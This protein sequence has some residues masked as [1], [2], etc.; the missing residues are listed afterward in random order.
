VTILLFAL[1]ASAPIPAELGPA[2]AEFS[3]VPSTRMMKTQID[4][5]TLGYDRGRKQLDFWLR[6]RVTS[7]TKQQE[8]VTWADTRTCPAARRLLASMRDIPVPKFAPV[9]SSKGP[10][11]ILDGV[12]YSLRTYSDQ[13]MLTDGT[14]VGTPLAV[15]IDSALKTLRPC[16]TARI[17]ER[18]R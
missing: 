7:G 2:W 11:V 16:W 15:W 4:V 14:N 8:E 12:G 17:P 5:G 6:R 9:G 1:L 13:G 18:T 10:P 3:R